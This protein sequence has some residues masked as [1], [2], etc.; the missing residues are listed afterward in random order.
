MRCPTSL[1]LILL[2]VSQSRIHLRKD[3]V[4][5]AYQVLRSGPWQ[6]AEECP[7]SLHLKHTRSVSLVS[8]TI[9]QVTLLQDVSYIPGQKD[10][11]CPSV[12]HWK[13]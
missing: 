3:K 4:Q 11:L 2:K 12:L 1:H 7:I 13:R 9:N 6:T 5:N 8:R 10:D